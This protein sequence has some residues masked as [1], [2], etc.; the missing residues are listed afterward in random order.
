MEFAFIGGEIQYIKKDK[1]YG[2][3]D[4]DRCQK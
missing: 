2:L 3:S 1:I 4:S